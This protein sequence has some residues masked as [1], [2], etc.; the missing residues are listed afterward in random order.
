MQLYSV[1]FGDALHCARI[2]YT[3]KSC[4]KSSYLCVSANMNT[5][6]SEPFCFYELHQ[7]HESNQ[8]HCTPGLRFCKHWCREITSASPTCW[9][10]KEPSVF[11]DPQKAPVQSCQFPTGSQR[12]GCCTT[13]MFP[14][15]APITARQHPCGSCAH[16]GRGFGNWG[17]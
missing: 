10:A 5:R 2:N 3:I 11:H 6:F 7:I 15:L 4:S 9:P 1:L 8:L 17:I 13:G 12:A 16:L 14:S